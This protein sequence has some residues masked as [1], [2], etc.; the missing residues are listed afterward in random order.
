MKESELQ[1]LG[2]F[3]IPLPIP[4]L[5]A[6]GPVNAYIIEEEQGFLLFDP[7]LGTEPA[8]AALV[9]GLERAGHR[10]E[11]VNRIVVSHGHID[12]FGSAAWV[13]ERAGRSIPIFVHSADRDKVLESGA[14]WPA[15]LRANSAYL[16]QLG[17]PAS[18]VEKTALEL[19]GNPGLGRRLPKVEHLL[20]GQKF[21]GKHVD[22]EVLHMPG[23]TCGICCLYERSHRLLFS[24]DHLLERVSPNPIIEFGAG[25]D[26]PAFKPLISY[27]ESLERIRELDIDLVLP[28]HATPFSDWRLVIESL[29]G[30]YRRR[31]EKILEILEGG[32]RTA[33]EIKR[34]LFP[35][36]DGFGVILTISEVL[37]NLEVMEQ[38]GEVLRKPGG[39]FIR[40]RK[41]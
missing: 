1:K 4:F 34:E 24:A 19:S 21:H 12:H 11:D 29:H 36:A 10:L 5:E 25:G 37:G 40:F 3:R 23:H 8:Q 14:D 26:P 32:P 16:A 9:K 17:V 39:E 18:L 33:Y 41:T 13:V 20:P 31:Q 15:L 28:G 2:I 35:P 30:F 38:R 22:L 7:G 6:G 27:F